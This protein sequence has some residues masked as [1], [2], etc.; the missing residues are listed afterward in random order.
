M[1]AQSSECSDRR[2]PALDLASLLGRFLIVT[3]V[4]GFFG[5]CAGHLLMSALAPVFEAEIQWLDPALRVDDV[6]VVRD[7]G[8][9]VIRLRVGLAHSISVNGRTFRADP[10][11][12]AVSSTLVGNTVVPLILL[13][14]TGFAFRVRT[15][16]DFLWR[17]IGMLVAA[18]LLCLV[19][20]PLVLWGEIWRLLLTAAN[21]RAP[22]PLLLW[23]DFVT[24]GVELPLAVA[25]GIA[26]VYAGGG[27]RDQKT[28]T[29]RT[30][31]ARSG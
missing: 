25:L 5:V 11:G 9:H 26:V 4:A 28:S 3:A 8:E 7:Q 23:D 1:A 15:A 10:R 30:S 18:G 19:G 13:L 6:T 24:G 20:A 27:L 22:S 16:A 14:A 17:V 12:Q 2:P 21:S 31:T 29:A